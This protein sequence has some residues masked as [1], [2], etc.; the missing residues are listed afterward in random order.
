MSDDR[1][2]DHVKVSRRTRAFGL[3]KLVKLRSGFA[4]FIILVLP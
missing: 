2:I 4:G 3:F 1:F